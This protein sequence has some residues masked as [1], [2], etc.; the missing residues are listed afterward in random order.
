MNQEQ[1]A[2]ISA[3]AIVTMS[4]VGAPAPAG[5]DRPPP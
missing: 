2:T 5:A 4:E 3:N 1:L